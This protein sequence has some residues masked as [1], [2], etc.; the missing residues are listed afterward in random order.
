MARRN[1][2]E[3]AKLAAE[4][5]LPT[6]VMSKHDSYAGDELSGEG[7]TR[8]AESQISKSSGSSSS[9]AKF[10]ERKYII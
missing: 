8:K 1:F 5:K 4:E 9:E 3:E 2:G 6:S 7:R 10:S